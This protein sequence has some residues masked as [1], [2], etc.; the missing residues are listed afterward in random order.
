MPTYH[1]FATTYMPSIDL[2][3]P[4]LLDLHKEPHQGIIQSA[5]FHHPLL[6]SSALFSADLGLASG[7]KRPC[8]APLVLEH[9]EGHRLPQLQ[10][11][12]GDPRA[13]STEPEWLSRR[14]QRWSEVGSNSLRQEPST[15][16]WRVRCATAVAGWCKA[17]NS[18]CRGSCWERSEVDKAHDFP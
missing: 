2:H 6:P 9:V 5:S 18:G 1:C 4:A 11:E 17:L 13:R 10:P 14:L 7:L 3:S 12:A 16:G 15:R 8:Q